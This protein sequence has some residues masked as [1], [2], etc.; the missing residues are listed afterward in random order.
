MNPMEGTI[1]NNTHITEL[2]HYTKLSL[3][4]AYRHSIAFE[5]EQEVASRVEEK[6][7]TF[8]GKFVPGNSIGKDSN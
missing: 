5:I 3:T 7:L 2:Q 8:Q 1:G 6:N 4:P